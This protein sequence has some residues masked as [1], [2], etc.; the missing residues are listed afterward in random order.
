MNLPST[1]KK[2]TRRGWPNSHSPKNNTHQGM[3]RNY[4]RPILIFQR[5]GG[6]APFNR[7]AR[8]G[9]SR[10]DRNKAVIKG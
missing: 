10:V 6:T 3:G 7:I 5:V 8:P 9:G 2:C 4:F 1:N